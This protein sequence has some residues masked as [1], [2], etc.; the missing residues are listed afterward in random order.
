MDSRIF[1]C[2]GC[3]RLRFSED[4]RA[5]RFEP[6]GKGIGIVRL[7]GELLSITCRTFFFVLRASQY[8]K[9]FKAMVLTMKEIRF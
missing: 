7:H 3:D 1:S 6:V 8:L 9:P 5:R 4:L 2:H